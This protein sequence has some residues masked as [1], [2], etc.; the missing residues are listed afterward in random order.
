MVVS[1][2]RAMSA[3]P[4]VHSHVWGPN[5]IYAFYIRIYIC[6]L[7]SD[8]IKEYFYVAND[9]SCHHTSVKFPSNTAIKKNQHIIGANENKFRLKDL[10]FKSHK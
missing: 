1:I 4:T 6:V 9:F 3:F 7:C 10:R 5:H 2:N 8:N